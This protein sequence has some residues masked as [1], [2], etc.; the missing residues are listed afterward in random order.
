MKDDK[1]RSHIKWGAKLNR[2]QTSITAMA[3][4]YDIIHSKGENIF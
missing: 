4:E 3:E 2:D 1:L